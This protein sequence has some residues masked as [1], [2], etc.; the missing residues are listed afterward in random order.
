M[1]PA[2]LA[3]MLVDMDGASREAALSHMTVT[4]VSALLVAGMTALSKLEMEVLDNL[5]VDQ[6]SS[7]LHRLEDLAAETNAQIVKRKQRSGG[8]EDDDGDDDDDAGK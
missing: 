2:V 4:E 7:R 1:E 8:G 5:T 3:M 6:L